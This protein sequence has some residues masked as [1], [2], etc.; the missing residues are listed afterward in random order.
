MVLA[1]I[2]TVTIP[3]GYFGLQYQNV[4]GRLAAEVEICA[5]QVSK[6]IRT[7]PDMWFYEQVRLEELLAQRPSSDAP[8]IRRI[9]DLKNTE[10][11]SGGVHPPPPTLSKRDVISDSGFAV[12]RLE[13]STSL[14]PV[15]LKTALVTLWSFL[16]GFVVYI[17]IRY[18]PL[19]ALLD[20]E[21]SLNETNEFLSKIMEN[22][23]NGILVLAPDTRVV[24][25]NQH[26]QDISG[27]DEDEFLRMPSF[28]DLIP[29]DE[30]DHVAEQ[31][32][33]LTEHKAP[34]LIFETNLVC[35]SGRLRYLSCG[36]APIVRDGS[37]SALVLSVDDITVRKESEARIRKMA[38]F[39]G[40]T[41]LPNRALFNNELEHA[42]AYA[43]RYETSFGLM[44][45]DI[46]N[47]KRINDTLGHNYGDQLLQKVAERL[48]ESVRKS[49][50]LSRP[51]TEEAGEV[52]ARLGGDEFTILLTCF[53]HEEDAAKVANRIIEKSAL[54]YLIEGQE[55]FV[56]LSIGIATYPGDG[57]SQDILF[58]NADTAMYHAKFLGK[59]TF[60]FYRSAMNEAALQRL[61]LENQLFKALERNEFQ[62]YYQPQVDMIS[63][64]IVGVEALLRWQN[65][66][67]GMVSPLDFI[68]IAE[69]NGLIIPITEWVLAEACRQNR[70]WQDSALP[71]V[72]VAVN[73]STQVL[74]QR[75]LPELISV[76]LE[77]SQLDPERLEVEITESVML[78]NVEGTIRL[79]KQVR[80]MGVSI[81][82]DDFGTGY[83]SFSY[84]KQLPVHAI[85]I[86]RSFVKD[87]PGNQEDIAIVK[88]IIATSHSLS[89]KVIAE[90]V[91]TTEQR[92][93]LAAHACDEF[94]GYL[95]SKPLCAA[96]I[97][98]L[99]GR[100]APP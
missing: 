74:K 52:V 28:L 17:A 99:L 86:D 67:L 26:M 82:I 1:I 98:A 76:A 69:E 25:A 3:V 19:R 23:T 55:V 36:A 70:A 48:V 77:Q 91:E 93:F 2:V 54:P 95:F 20:A 6:L 90:G 61:N 83:S 49:D 27:F 14:R 18:L 59:N 84:L 11:A 72:R 37:I 60:Q 65:P 92:Q 71:A 10:I 88:A 63:G 45:I 31:L 75:D 57:T 42:I 21:K 7:N 34:S 56:T 89:L 32:R 12:A 41:N 62:L 43:K 68:P 8:E 22:S 13:I 79:L 66:E 78:H 5:Q 9:F 24:M 38:Y 100:S 29:A 80:D 16:F 58:R 44:L 85:K 30:R 64:S 97:T 73:I 96:D 40:L 35:Q 51:A 39:D 15:I 94:Q 53:N 33:S 46:D 50:Y 47:F 4:V 81:S 87:L